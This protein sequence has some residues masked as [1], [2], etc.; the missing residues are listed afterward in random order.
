MKSFAP[1]RGTIALMA[2]AAA[3]APGCAA[4][5]ATQQPS[6]RNMAVLDHGV[7]RTH[8]IAELGAP[9]WSN[10]TDDGAVDVFSFKQGF[11]KTTKVARALVHG[12]ADVATFGLWEVVGIPAESVLDGTDV[13]L[14]VHY[15]P[16]QAVDHVVIIKGEKAVHPPKLFAFG[17]NRGKSRRTAVR[18][19]RPPRIVESEPD[20]IVASDEQPVVR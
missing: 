16:D 14:E 3:F 2:L 13:Q 15:D 12:A 18:R 1:R 11:T 4:V 5:K 7:P 9:V 20:V 8:V 19:T 10:Q 6:K 17:G